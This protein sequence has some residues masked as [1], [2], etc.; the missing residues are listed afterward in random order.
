[1]NHRLEK[2]VNQLVEA[3]IEDYDKGRDID[4]AVENFTNPNKDDIIK[5]L[6]QLRNVIFPGRKRFLKKKMGK[7]VLY[8]LLD[9]LKG[10]HSG[11][12]R[13]EL[14]GQLVIRNSCSNVEDSMW[15]DYCI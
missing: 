14:S 6:D 3:I 11:V 10:K 1:M 12:V 9:R 8:L 5:I 13:T 7:F 15:S 4:D 2:E